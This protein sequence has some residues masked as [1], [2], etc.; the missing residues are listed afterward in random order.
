MLFALGNTQDMLKI[1]LPLKNS[2]STS[3]KYFLT[4]YFIEHY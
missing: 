4:K 3:I 2:T 1:N